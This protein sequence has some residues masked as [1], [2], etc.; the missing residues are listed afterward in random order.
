MSLATISIPSADNRPAEAPLT[1]AEQARYAADYAI[2]P[3]FA[4][5]RAGSKE[6]RAAAV[7][8]AAKARREA[9]RF[10]AAARQARY[11]EGLAAAHAIA[12]KAE[13]AAKPA[14]IK[15]T[16][17]TETELVTFQRDGNVVMITKTDGPYLDRYTTSLDHA[18]AEYRRLRQAGFWNW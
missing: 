11:E 14:K 6:A 13:T 15:I 5:A 4:I 8:T 12:A 18:R 9:N 7:K 16:L 10:E 3:S 2:H 1:L 17:A